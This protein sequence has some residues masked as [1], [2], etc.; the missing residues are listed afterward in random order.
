ML[1]T[2]VAACSSLSEPSHRFAQI[3]LPNLSPRKRNPDAHLSTAIALLGLQQQVRQ[4]AIVRLKIQLFAGLYFALRPRVLL[5]TENLWVEHSRQHKH[6]GDRLP[7]ET[8][9]RSSFLGEERPIADD[10][11]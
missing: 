6:Q 5:P 4:A 1:R 3:W 10:L 11:I 2:W 7:P 8:A 9:H